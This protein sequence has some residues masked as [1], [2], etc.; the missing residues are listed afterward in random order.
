VA[1]VSR[2]RIEQTEDGAP[3]RLLLGMVEH[4]VRYRFLVHGRP[5]LEANPGK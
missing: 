3:I 5:Q 2:Q 1:G 4:P